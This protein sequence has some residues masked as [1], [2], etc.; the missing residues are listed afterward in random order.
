MIGTDGPDTIEYIRATAPMLSV[1]SRDTARAKADELITAADVAMAQGKMT[2]GEYAEARS[3]IGTYS[4]MNAEG[5]YRR[6]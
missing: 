6:Y 3:M 2:V 4:A 1:M 5:N